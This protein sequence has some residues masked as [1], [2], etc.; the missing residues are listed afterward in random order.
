MSTFS[1]CTSLVDVE[2]PSTL[3][4]IWSSCFNDCPS[5]K[6]LV[7]P[8]GLTKLSPNWYSGTTTFESLTIG[9]SLE[10]LSEL[11]IYSSDLQELKVSPDNP[12]YTAE[13]NIL[14]TKGKETLL[15]YPSLKLETIRE[16]VIDDAVKVIDNNAFPYVEDPQVTFIYI[17]A[18]LE[19][20]Y[21]LPTFDTLR[22]YTVSPK[23]QY[24]SAENG[25]LYNKEKTNLY[26][27]GF[28]Y[29]TRGG[30][31]NSNVLLYHHRKNV[32]QW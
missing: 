27:F 13:D 32:C 7:L 24:F 16:L 28:D 30:G 20:F 12:Y 15:S 5:L 11:P 31:N 10:D 4:W 3:E 22:S 6:E 9:A 25:W 26:D 2:L 14:Y 19:N 8:D 23:N 17:G 1:G 21:D 29:C 18:S